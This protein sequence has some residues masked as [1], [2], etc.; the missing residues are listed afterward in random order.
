MNASKT[1]CIDQ[2][3]KVIAAAKESQFIREQLRPLLDAGWAGCET[4]AHN[5]IRERSPHVWV[6]AKPNQDGSFDIYSG[7]GA[8][9]CK[10]KSG[11]RGPGV[12]RQA[13]KGGRGS[14]SEL[15]VSRART[16]EVRKSARSE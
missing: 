12:R 8:V 13:E 4:H 11:R 6:A 5:T 10:V 15:A 1:V 2:I 7:P 16:R 9:Y 14:G 3:P